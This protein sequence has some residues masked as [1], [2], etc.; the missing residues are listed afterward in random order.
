MVEKI[1][2]DEVVET[3]CRGTSEGIVIYGA[4]L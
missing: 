1:K 2:S 3:I 4:G